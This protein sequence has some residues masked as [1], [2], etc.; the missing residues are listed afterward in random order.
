MV[1][2]WIVSEAIHVPATRSLSTLNWWKRRLDLVRTSSATWHFKRLLQQHS[3]MKLSYIILFVGLI[4][5][6]Q[7]VSMTSS[8]RQFMT[9]FQDVM[10]LATIAATTTNPNQAWGI[11]MDPTLGSSVK[12]PFVYSAEWTGTKLS[13]LNLQQALQAENIQQPGQWKMGRWP[14]PIL[15][16]PATE[17]DS[18]WF[19][20]SNLQT[21]CDLLQRTAQAEG[22]VG[23]A[24]Q[25]C[26]VDA[27]LV[28]LE[29][30]GNRRPVVM[31]NPHIIARSPE[32]QVLV[33][34][35]QCLVLP[36]TFVATVLRDTWVDVA[37]TTWQGQ[38]RKIRL[39][40]EASRCAQHELDHDR[41]ILVTDHVGLEEL[42]SDL[43][44]LV[45]RPGHDERMQLAYARLVFDQDTI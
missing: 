28:Y 31:V 18:R 41:G 5:R 6:V 43:M 36:P 22:A 7:G 32:T 21:A 45:E 20:S 13:L 34:E 2:P 17:V 33:W 38:K 3:S 25:Q 23:L 8:R 44:R 26:G 40:G 35:E 19:G 9:S 39:L 29:Q 42:E 16:R 30:G 37:Y 24:A 12:H 14:D 10:T 4:F 1:S 15:R 27:R 11:D